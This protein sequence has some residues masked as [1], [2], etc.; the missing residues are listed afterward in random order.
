MAHCIKSKEGCL[1]FTRAAKV[2]IL[3]IKIELQ[4]LTWWKVT[5]HYK[6][7]PNQLKRLKR[8]EK[9]HCLKSR[10]IFSEA[11]QTEQCVSSDF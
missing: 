2:E 11:F 7:Y 9:L 10:P 4:N 8:V 1:S 5:T 3:N 6:V